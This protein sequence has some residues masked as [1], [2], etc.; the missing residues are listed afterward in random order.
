MKTIAPTIA[1]AIFTPDLVEV[2]DRLFSISEYDQEALDVLNSPQVSKLMDYKGQYVKIKTFKALPL[3]KKA[4]DGEPVNPSTIVLKESEYVCRI[5]INYDRIGDVIAKRANGELP[6]ENAGMSWGE[7]VPGLENYVKRH[8]KKGET[9]ANLYFRLYTCKGANQYKRA[10]YFVNGK[11][12]D[13]ETAQSFCTK[14]SEDGDIKDCFEI[15]IRDIVEVN[16]QKLTVWTGGWKWVR[17]GP[18]FILVSFLNYHDK[19]VS[20]YHN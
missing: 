17:N 10:Q 2:D 5:G 13:K 1:L 12:V 20:Q 4:V 16:G 7:W 18:F 6:A 3:R 15:Y 14:F 19:V 8:T 9:V 11:P